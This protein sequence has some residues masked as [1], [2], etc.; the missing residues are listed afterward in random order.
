MSKKNK[1]VYSDIQP[2]AKEAGVWVNTTDGNVKIEKDGKWVDDGGSG[3]GSE[4]Q[5]MYYR[6]DKTKDIEIDT[7]NIC[8]GL[9]GGCAYVRS[10]WYGTIEI[11]SYG[12]WMYGLWESG[13]NFGK[14]DIFKY[15][16][17]ICFIPGKM[18]T[19]QNGELKQYNTL[20]E[21]FDDHGGYKA[22]LSFLIPI[23]KEE[24]YSS[25]FFS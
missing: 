4:A 11:Q 25:E 9:L 16:T 1:I 6:I 19:G 17:G 14:N 22:D 5:P 10:E 12:K 8:N 24:F 21:F 15:V 18:H 20:K 3:N 13:G 23:S 2:N 7:Y